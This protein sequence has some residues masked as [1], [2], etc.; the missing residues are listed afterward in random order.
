MLI[1]TEENFYNY[2]YAYCE[3]LII[4]VIIVHTRKKIIYTIIISFQLA[5]NE[6]TICLD[7]S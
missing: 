5:N 6:S 7:I 2:V 1:I 4:N 3:T